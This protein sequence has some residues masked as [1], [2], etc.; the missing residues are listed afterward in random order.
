MF[1]KDDV[2]EVRV[3][4]ASEII[5]DANKYDRLQLLGV[6]AESLGVNTMG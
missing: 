1:K 4:P 3:F 6:V 2:G 5:V